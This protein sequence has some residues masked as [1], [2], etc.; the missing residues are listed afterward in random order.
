MEEYLNGTADAVQFIRYLTG[1]PDV[2][3]TGHNS[4]GTH[5]NISHPL[6]T[7]A[8]I[9]NVVYSMNRTVAALPVTMKGVDDVR[10]KMFG[11][12]QLYGGFFTNAVDGNV[13]TE[14]KLF[15]TTYDLKEFQ[16]YVKVCEGLTKCLEL[17]CKTDRLKQGIETIPY[18]DNLYEVVY[19]GA[20][21]VIKYSSFL[22]TLDGLRRENNINGAYARKLPT[23]P[24][25]VVAVPQVNEDDD[26][27]DDDYYDDDDIC[28]CDDCRADRGEF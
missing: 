2:M 17:L 18:V 4:I 25:P 20:K 14:G 6:L 3:N 16:G 22:G 8:N 5:I 27:D 26:Y 23:D 10:K 1:N 15:R 28:N 19:E 21:P 24:A 9:N 7:N 13:W 11:R 12:T